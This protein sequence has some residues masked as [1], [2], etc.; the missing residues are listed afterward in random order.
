ML[1]I[2]AGSNAMES[3]TIYSH[4]AG[5]ATHFLKLFVQQV[6]YELRVNSHYL[7]ILSVL[8]LKAQLL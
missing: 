8:P 2:S 7:E 5:G 4:N 1:Q 6:S 3:I